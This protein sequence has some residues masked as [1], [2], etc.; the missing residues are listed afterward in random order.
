MLEYK[1]VKRSVI[2]SLVLH[3]LLFTLA[4]FFVRAEKQKEKEPFFARIVTPEELREIPGRETQ[5]QPRTAPSPPSRPAP[6]TRPQGKTELRASREKPAAKELPRTEL[7]K[8]GLEPLRTPPKSD[9]SRAETQRPSAPPAPSSVPQPSSQGAQPGAK[10]QARGQE[11][12]AR[13]PATREKLFDKD[14]LAKLSKR[15]TEGT[16]PESSITFDTRDFKYYAYMKRLREKI[17]NI[18]VYPSEAAERGIYGDLY[19]QFTI[20]KNGKLGPV[21]LVRT[22]GYRALDEAAIRA[23]KDADPYWPLPEDW[24]KDELTIKGHFVY[25]LY[26]TYIR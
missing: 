3:I 1:V 12:A 16:R 9:T 13:Q 20:R 7:G 23:L 26:G 24:G 11:P 15:E 25:S 4:F 14:I 10:P 21:E 5:R 17:E 19:I 18:W 22:S 2:Y 6:K 8:T